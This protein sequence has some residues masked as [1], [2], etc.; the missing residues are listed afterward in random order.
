MNISWQSPTFY[1][2]NYNESTQEKTFI[3]NGT[4][5]C[6]QEIRETQLRSYQYRVKVGLEAVFY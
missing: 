4:R 2:I 3:C 6:Y 1:I 5:I